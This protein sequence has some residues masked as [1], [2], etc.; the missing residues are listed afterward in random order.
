MLIRFL[1]IA[2]LTTGSAAFA[3]NCA[4]LLTTDAKLLPNPTTKID[5]AVVT[6]PR[7]LQDNT[8]FWPEHCEVIGRINE[9]TGMYSQRYAIRFHLRLPKDWNE[10]FFFEGGG[11]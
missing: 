11:G 6:P 2:G 3:Q 5:F 4:G 8:P 1:L 7:V 10:G 9:R